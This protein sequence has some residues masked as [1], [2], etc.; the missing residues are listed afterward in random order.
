MSTNTPISYFLNLTMWQ[1]TKMIDTVNK[2]NEE[3]EKQNGR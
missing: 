3:R 1:L 2:I